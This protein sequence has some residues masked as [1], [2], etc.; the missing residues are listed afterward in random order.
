[1]HIP[2]GSHFIPALALA[3]LLIDGTLPPEGTV[4]PEDVSPF[5]A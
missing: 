2:A 3:V 4:C 1:M 5:G